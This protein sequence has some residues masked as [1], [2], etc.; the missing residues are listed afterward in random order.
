MVLG[1]K[2]AGAVAVVAK[3]AS[4]WRQESSIWAGWL[5]PDYVL[6]CFYRPGLL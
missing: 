1:Q 4:L 6:R 3:G 2:K 5:A